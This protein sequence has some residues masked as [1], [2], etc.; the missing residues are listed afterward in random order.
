MSPATGWSAAEERFEET[1][2]RA[3][4]PVVGNGWE[5]VTPPRACITVD[6]DSL[7]SGD[8]V[9]DSASRD[10]PGGGRDRKTGSVG[11]IRADGDAKAGLGEPKAYN[12]AAAPAEISNGML[13]LHY[14][15]GQSP[16]MVQRVFEKRVTRLT[17]DLTPMYSM[18]GEDDRAMMVVRLTYMD[19]EDHVLGEIRHDLYQV[20]TDDAGQS[21]GVYVIKEKGEFDGEPRHIVID[22][23]AIL[24]QKLR[25]VDSRK[26]ARTRLSFEVSSSLCGAAVEGYVD[27]VVATLAEGAG[28]MRLTKA[29]IKALV[30]VGMHFHAKEAQGF[31]KV[32]MDA[33]LKAYGREKI[34]AW[35]AEIPKT[36]R[37][38][39]DRLLAL[40]KETYGL[41]GKEAFE[42]AFAIQYL[43]QVMG[44]R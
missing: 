17:V 40:V 7:K 5:V 23:G 20:A 3:D 32:W 15:N 36:V 8:P 28:L 10:G 24:Q 44:G 9:K 41:S 30:E 12:A 16:T 18:A 6:E 4:A 42:T 11:A 2:N 22:A 25:Q 43:L 26:I 29:E 39:P 31:G 34:M 37:T 27:N 13:Y 38:D 35:L 1:F 19:Y 21:D 33:S 14:G